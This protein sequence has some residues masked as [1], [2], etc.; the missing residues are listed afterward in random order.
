MIFSFNLKFY[1]TFQYVN[2]L[3]VLNILNFD[4]HPRI[5]MLESFLRSN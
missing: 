5:P 2:L 3:I 1:V 4:L